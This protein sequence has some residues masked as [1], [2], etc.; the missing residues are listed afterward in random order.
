MVSWLICCINSGFDM[1]D[2]FGSAAVACDAGLQ[3]AIS[4]WGEKPLRRAPCT[5][6]SIT[7]NIYWKHIAQDLG[8]TL[9]RACSKASCVGIELDMC[10][11]CL[12]K[13]Q[14]SPGFWHWFCSRRKVFSKFDGLYN[15]LLHGLRPF[16]NSSWHALGHCKKD[17]MHLIACPMISSISCEV[18]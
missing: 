15:V 16:H 18:L 12:A 9:F 4:A 1:R 17:S 5:F 2:C 13:C 6:R 10:D 8:V 14:C 11:T 7:S 3:A